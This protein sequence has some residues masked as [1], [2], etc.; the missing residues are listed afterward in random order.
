[1][2]QILAAQKLHHH[3]RMVRFVL[4]EIVNVQDVV[5]RDVAGHARFGEESRLGLRVFASG[6]G[7][8]LDGDHAPDHRVAR[9]VDVRHAAS[10]KLLE[11]VLADSCRKLH[12]GFATSATQPR[13]AKY[14]RSKIGGFAVT[15]KR[16]VTGCP[17]GFKTGRP[18]LPLRSVIS[19]SWPT[20][21]SAS[22]TN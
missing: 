10:Q 6:V 1:M 21:L 12:Q 19:I 14:P 22:P 16:T 18:C 20:C 2:A 11:L 9:L 15:T 4:A 3:V 17:A 7:Q 8:H 5:V 13:P